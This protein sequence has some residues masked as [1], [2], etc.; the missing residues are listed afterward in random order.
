MKI[1]TTHYAATRKEWRAWLKK[2][3][4]KLDEIW[5]V[6]FKKGSGKPRVAYDDAVEE[7][8]C[9]G[10]IDSVI[11]RIDEEKYAQR[12]TPRRDGSKWSSL[13]IKRMKKLIDEGAMT[14]AG[15]A[16]FDL[17]LLKSKSAMTP[18]PREVALPAYL[19]KAIMKDGEAWE[20]FSTLAPSHRKNYILWIDSAKREETRQRRISEAISLLKKKQKL[21]M[22]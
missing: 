22:K 1:T 4:K 20:Y 11:Q 9:F 10:W 7:A 19:K 15:L 18:R 6:Y 8:L 3:H 5:L 14:K 16:K 13:N 17:D 2:N 12:F 21:G